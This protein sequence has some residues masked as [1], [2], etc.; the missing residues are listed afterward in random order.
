MRQQ[1]CMAIVLVLASCAMVLGCEQPTPNLLR[2]KQIESR[3]ELVGGP[4][5]YADLGDFLIENDKVSQTA[6]KIP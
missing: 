2:A 6:E 3:H 5:A 4:V 1:S